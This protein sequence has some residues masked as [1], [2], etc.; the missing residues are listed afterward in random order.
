MQE[1]LPYINYDNFHVDFRFKYKGKENNK[2]LRE[3][4]YNLGVEKTFKNYMGNPEVFRKKTKTLGFV[5][6]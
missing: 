2:H 3:Y 6:I 1:S 5:K 4:M